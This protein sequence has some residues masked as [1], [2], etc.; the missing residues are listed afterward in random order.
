MRLFTDRLILRIGLK[1]EFGLRM[2]LPLNHSH[3]ILCQRHS[4]DNLRQCTLLT[5]QPKITSFDKPFDHYPG[6]KRGR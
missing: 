6:Q 3:K 4:M 5:R 2:R 1:R